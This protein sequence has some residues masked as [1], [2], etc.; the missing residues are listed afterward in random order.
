[1]TVG[2]HPRCPYYSPPKTEKHCS[3]CGEGIFEGE[4]YVENQDGDS[5]H[6]ECIH[7]IRWLLGWTGLE[8]KYGGG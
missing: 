3:V 5:V 4:E 1:M 7:N 6:V 2:H 8:I